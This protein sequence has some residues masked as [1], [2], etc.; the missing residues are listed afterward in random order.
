[1]DEEQ[2]TRKMLRRY[3]MVDPLVSEE[4]PW[5]ERGACFQEQSRRYHVSISTL[6][7]YCKRYREQRQEGLKPKAS[8]ADKGQPRRIPAAILQKAVELRED[9]PGRSTTQIIAMLDRLYPEQA[10][11]IKRSTLARHFQQLGKTRRALRKQQK[12]GYRHFRKR[13]KGDLWQTDI[14]QPDLQVRDVDGEIKKAVLVALLD[15]ATGFCVAAEFHT[16]LDGGIVESV[17]C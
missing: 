6:K 7:R 1:M 5:G 10:G 17:V 8:R 11:Q 4:V 2:R 9:Q 14:C 15:N 3:A 16:T 12:A 13:H